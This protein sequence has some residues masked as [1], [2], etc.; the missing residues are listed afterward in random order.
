MNKQA[1]MKSFEKTPQE[2]LKS[3]Y[4]RIPKNG[5]ITFWA[6]F[7]FG[8]AV[9]L[10]IFTNTLVNHDSTLFLII[11]QDDLNSGRWFS[12]EIYSLSG[13]FTLPVV[14]G[15]LSIILISLSAA[16]TVHILE[17]KSR[18]FCSI[19]GMAM[20][21]FPVIACSFTYMHIADSFHMALFL[22]V[23]SVFFAKKRG[24]R[25]GLLAAVLLMLSTGIYQAYSQ[26]TLTL[27]VI[28]ILLD[29][30]EKENKLFDIFRKGIRYCIVWAGGVAAYRIVLQMIFFINQEDTIFGSLAITD[31]FPNRIRTVLSMF[32]RSMFEFQGIWGYTIVKYLYILSI[33]LS[34][35]FI[36]FYVWRRCQKEK[37]L[38]L[39]FCGILFCCIPI[40]QN[41]LLIL[42]NGRVHNLTRYSY[43]LSV[44]L[45]LKL[46]DMIEVSAR[47]NLYTWVCLIASG[48]VLWCN[49]LYS[50]ECYLNLQL[51]NMNSYALA[52]RI[53]D[54]IETTPGWKED[55]P[56]LFVGNYSDVTEKRD[57]QP[58]LHA[59]MQ[60]ATGT[61]GNGIIYYR[62]YILYVY[63]ND[64]IGKSFV[65][66][67]E[68][69]LER[70]RQSGEVENMGNFPQEG[71]VKIIDGVMVVKLYDSDLVESD[72]FYNPYPESY[73]VR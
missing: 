12:N 60:D 31:N 34:I 37:W 69:D 62:P 47:K 13:I 61:M 64:Y 46:I 2:T 28:L 20:V 23:L 11:S 43:I 40:A 19:I 16:F 3:V 1:I 22:S 32:R 59:R 55:M 63:I 18:L 17:V 27:F 26:F 57:T 14:I 53:V 50:N 72:I 44:M 51:V 35:V 9:H 48:I 6:S 24:V 68:E 15:V 30:M 38:R 70:I 73:I 25:S 67:T 33:L 49:F 66:A 10:Y 52:N 56:V 39:I 21:S 4:N 29:V 54:R 5:I 8:M 58:I 45:I 65:H 41:I 36:G 71:S 42:T 7:I